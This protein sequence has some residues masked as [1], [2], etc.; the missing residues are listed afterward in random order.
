M[1]EYTHSQLLAHLIA[2]EDL[3]VEQSRWAFDQIM[4]GLW[5][6]AQIAGLLIALAAKGESVEEIT[7]AAQAMRAHVVPVDGGSADVLDTCGTGGTGISTFNISTTAALVAAGAGATVAKHGNRTNTRASGSANVLGAL[8]VKLDCGPAVEGRCLR[9][10]RICFC[11]AIAHHPAMR[12]AAPVRKQLGVRTLF[13]VLGPLTN[14]AGARRQLLGVPNAELTETMARVLASLGARRAMVVHGGGL[15]ELTTTAP[16]T[17]AEL[18]DGQVRTFTL[19]ATELGLKRA[20]LEDL[21]VD[22]PEASAERARAVLAGRDGPCRDIVLLN[23]AAALV[24]A[25]LAE[26]LSAGLHLAANSI[27]SGAA[28]AALERLVALSNT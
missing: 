24:V 4:Q 13:N 15:D 27:D 10:A 2:R 8:G 21:L 23:A 7:G 6:E 5:G 12:F 1:A 28:G 25:D 16:T 14:P 11:F 26:D 18:V 19:D 20:R 22:S 17:V 3:S 9:E